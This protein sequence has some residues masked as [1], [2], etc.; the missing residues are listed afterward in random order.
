MTSVRTDTSYNAAL[1]RII[2]PTVLNLIL[3]LLC[4]FNV[5]S[6]CII[7]GRALSQTKLT[8]SAKSSKYKTK[9]T[10]ADGSANSP[11]YIQ[12]P[13][14]Q[15]IPNSTHLLAVSDLNAISVVID[16]YSVL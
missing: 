16:A 8:T 3:F 6:I 15:C 12:H 10:S 9:L 11:L 1:E 7:S 5:L 13:K 2:F 14:S 4:V